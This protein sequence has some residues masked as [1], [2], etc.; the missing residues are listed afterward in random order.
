MAKTNFEVDKDKLEVRI[1][2]VFEATPERLWK[3]HTDPEQIAQWWQNTT[4]DKHD[5]KVGGAWR[6][7]DKGQGDGKEHAFNGVYKEIDEPHKISRTFE[8]EPWAGHV[9][10]ETVTF[11]PQDGGKTLVTS[12]AKY[13]NLDDLNGMVNSGME[14]G[15]T[16]GFERIAKLVEKS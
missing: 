16:A 2:R 1:T 6:Y 3:A 5:F 11:E 12:I 10:L 14:R 4:I 9:M 7:I 8:Y 13:D 15:A